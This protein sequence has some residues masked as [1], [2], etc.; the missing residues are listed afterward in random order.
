MSHPAHSVS[1]SQSPEV[2]LYIKACQLVAVVIFTSVRSSNSL[3]HP[4]LPLLAEVTLPF[5][6]TVIS[7]FV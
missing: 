2:E 6:S 1:F 5:A 7:A 4:Q 3:A